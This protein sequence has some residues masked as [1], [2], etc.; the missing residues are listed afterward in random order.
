MSNRARLGLVALAAAVAVAAFVLAGSGDEEDK[1]G[2]APAPA[3]TTTEGDPREPTATARSAP[4][5]PVEVRLRGYRP[6]GGIQEIEVE[7]GEEVRLVVLSDAPDDIHV[8]G[9]DLERE[10]APRRPATFRFAADLEGIFEIESHGAEHEGG[11]PLIAR[12]VVKPG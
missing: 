11:N 12:L 3:R 8:H 1:D 6:V 4:E 10:I 5:P 7:S 9:Y 2:S